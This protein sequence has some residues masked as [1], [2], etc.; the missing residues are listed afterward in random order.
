MHKKRDD[1]Y[2]DYNDDDHDDDDDDH[3]GQPPLKCAL[4]KHCF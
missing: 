3:F 2:N 4:S 1:D